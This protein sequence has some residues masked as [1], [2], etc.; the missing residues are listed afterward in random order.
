MPRANQAVKITVQRVERQKNG[1]YR[2]KIKEKVRLSGLDYEGMK[3]V[4]VT[5]M[6][7]GRYIM[8]ALP[9]PPAPPQLSGLKLRTPIPYNQEAV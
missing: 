8:R 9:R 7:R 5:N 2:V 3:L 6:G 1:K 4:T